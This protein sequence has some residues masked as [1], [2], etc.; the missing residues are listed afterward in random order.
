MWE[1]FITISL[2]VPSWAGLASFAIA[3]RQHCSSWN[4]LFYRL[5][6]M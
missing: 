3:F 6:V 2:K 5:N 4:T 1:L